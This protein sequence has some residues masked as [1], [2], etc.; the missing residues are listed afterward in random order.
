MLQK[1]LVPEQRL[2]LLASSRSVVSDSLRPHGLQHARL[3]GPSLSPG[4]CPNACP[5]SRRCHRTISSS[6]ALFSFCHQSFPAQSRANFGRQWEQ[7]SLARRSPWGRRVGHD[8]A[9]EQHPGVRTLCSRCR[10]PISIPNQGTRIP[11]AGRCSHNQ[12]ESHDVMSLT[13]GI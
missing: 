10:G 4:V 8:W 11:Q 5:L 7:G 1:G 3:S 12:N 9:T 13:C 6:V 2:L